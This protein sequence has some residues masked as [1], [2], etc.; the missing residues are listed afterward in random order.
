[1]R[2]TMASARCGEGLGPS[3]AALWLCG[4]AGRHV[5]EQGRARQGRG[6]EEGTGYLAEGALLLFTELLS[7]R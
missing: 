4:T 6:T 7:V 5:S 3:P 2:N 1:M